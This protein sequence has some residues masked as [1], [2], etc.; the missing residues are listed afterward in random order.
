MSPFG[1]IKTAEL[2]KGVLSGHPFTML[3]STGL[4]FPTLTVF[5]CKERVKFRPVGD[6][7]LN[8]IEF[9][10]VLARSATIARFIIVER[11]SADWNSPEYLWIRPGMLQ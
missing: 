10:L 2:K 1:I 6:L 3:T 4:Q 11:A 8:R 9:N 5:A 7:P